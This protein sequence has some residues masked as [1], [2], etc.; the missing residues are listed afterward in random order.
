MFLA[1]TGRCPEARRE[2]RQAAA[3]YRVTDVHYY[4][5]RGPRHLRRPQGGGPPRRARPW[6]GG[7]VADLRTNPDMQ[8]RAAMPRSGD[9]ASSGPRPERL[10]LDDDHGVDGRTSALGRSRS[11]T[12]YFQTPRPSASSRPVVSFAVGGSKHVASADVP[13]RSRGRPLRWPFCT[14]KVDL[15]RLPV[16][17]STATRSRRLA[18]RDDRHLVGTIVPVEL[19][20]TV[21]STGMHR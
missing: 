21:L 19:K 11:T 1:G 8:E 17:R 2:A 5:A 6:T 3:R 4:A 16:P 9:A 12:S 7:S 15:E 14:L 18:G 20:V 13:S 10:T